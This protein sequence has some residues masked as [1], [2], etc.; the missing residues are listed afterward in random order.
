MYGYGVLIIHKGVLKAGVASHSPAGVE[1]MEAMRVMSALAQPTRLGVYQLLVEK[2]P[3]GLAAG[4]IA[5]VVEMSPNGMTAH[6]T[7]LTAAGLVSSEKIGRTVIYKAETKPVEAL[8][9]FLADAVE[10]GEQARP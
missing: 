2:L 5:R 7:I 10:R 8:S 4:E 1:K 3:D 9:A 6:F